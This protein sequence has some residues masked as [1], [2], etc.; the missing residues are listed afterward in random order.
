V[1]ARSSFA[2]SNRANIAPP[3]AI[4]NLAAGLM[5]YAHMDGDS[6]TLAEFKKF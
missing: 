5:R 2:W 3:G 6:G 1:K 4:V